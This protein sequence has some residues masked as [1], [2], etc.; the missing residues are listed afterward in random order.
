MVLGTILGAIGDLIWGMNSAT[1]KL[2]LTPE[3]YMLYL[4]LL[5]RGDTIT[6]NNLLKNAAGKKQ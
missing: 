5:Q 6:A 2:G 4:Q 1:N 3:E